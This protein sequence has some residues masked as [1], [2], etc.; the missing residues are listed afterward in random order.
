[1]LTRTSFAATVPIQTEA[2]N[3]IAIPAF[4]LTRSG[5]VLPRRAHRPLPCESFHEGRA[6]MHYPITRCHH[7]ATSSPSH[8][9]TETT[10]MN[11]RRTTV[12][13]HWGEG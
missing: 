11:G 8:D 10:T 4:T 3:R 2:A 7:F 6:M 12:R 5:I 1:V 9:T 13:Q